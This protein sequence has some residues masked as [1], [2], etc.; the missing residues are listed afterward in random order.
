MRPRASAVVVRTSS[1]APV[2]VTRAF[3]AP[4]PLEDQPLAPG[5]SW[6]MA[7]PAEGDLGVLGEADELQADVAD[8]ARRR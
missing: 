4:V 8:E 3:G 1:P 7:G 5:W 2:A 6:R